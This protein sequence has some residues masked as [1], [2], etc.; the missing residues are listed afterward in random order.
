MI[1][2]QVLKAA[3]RVLADGLSLIHISTYAEVQEDTS[4]SGKD[5]E[6][7]GVFLTSINTYKKL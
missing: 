1:C 7:T 4:E 2:L 5:L 6:N 3:P